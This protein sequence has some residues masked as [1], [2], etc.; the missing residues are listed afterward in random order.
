VPVPYVD[1]AGAR[2][3][4][5][6]LGEGGPATVEANAG[7]WVA[8]VD[9]GWARIITGFVINGMYA[10]DVLATPM[11][12]L[13]AVAALTAL[14]HRDELEHH[15]RFALR[16]NPS[17]HVREVILQ[18]AVYAGVPAALDGMRVFERVVGEEP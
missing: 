5:E 14:G 11:R 17:E 7:R 10:R 18:M 8:R 4:T 15:I 13:C 2:A 9:E 16:T 6:M 1:E 3:A 12:E